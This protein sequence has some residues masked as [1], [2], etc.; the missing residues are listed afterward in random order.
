VANKSWG[1]RLRRLSFSSGIAS[2]M[3]LAGTAAMAGPDAQ[4][5]PYPKSTFLPDMEVDW[6]TLD[7]KAPGSDLWPM[8]WDEDGSVYA[9]WGDG[10]GFG[11]DDD[12]DVYVSIGLA[13]LKGEKA[14][15][16]TGENLIG[17]ISP[18]VAPCFAPAGGRPEM[19]DQPNGRTPAR[20]KACTASQPRLWLWMAISTRSSP[21]ARAWPTTRSHGSSRHARA[22]TT[23]VGRTGPSIRSRPPRAGC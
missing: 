7:R 12:K 13:R 22:P 15:T 19:R 20:A 17:G 21:R 8:T 10:G 16:I 14:K 6:S 1:Q 5:A 2:V 4:G 18:K 23:G 3:A 9:T 11:D